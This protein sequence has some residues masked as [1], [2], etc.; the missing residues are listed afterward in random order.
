M[1]VFLP[2]VLLVF[3]VILH[4]T[5]LSFFYGLCLDFEERLCV[6]L[7]LYR[8]KIGLF[9]DVRQTQIFVDLGQR[10]LNLVVWTL[11]ELI[12]NVI[13][14]FP[15]IL[16][17]VELEQVLEL[18]HLLIVRFCFQL[19]KQDRL[20][21]C[22]DARLQL[23]DLP[24]VVLNHAC[25]ASFL[26]PT[27]HYVANIDKQ[28]QSNES[29]HG[30]AYSRPRGLVLDEVCKAHQVVVRDHDEAFVELLKERICSINVRSC[31]AHVDEEERDSCIH[32]E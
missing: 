15:E 10:T 5:D 31:K 1:F 26:D 20:M 2:I 22:A 23:A 27:E 13:W 25:S 11:E 30:P 24:V 14:D 12:Q 19:A 32:D 18:S 29:N 16:I 7:L 4:D 17:A 3:P 28:V 8:N 21:L 6:L 9:Y